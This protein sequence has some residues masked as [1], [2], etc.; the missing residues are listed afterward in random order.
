MPY[1]TLFDL[2]Q[3]TSPLS[4]YAILYNWYNL[5]VTGKLSTSI[6]PISLN[7]NYLN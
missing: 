4:G 1:N 2:L 5:G 3:S 7:P 6:N